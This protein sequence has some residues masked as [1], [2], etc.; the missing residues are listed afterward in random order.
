M[1]QAQIKT[2]SYRKDRNNGV[3]T[4]FAILYNLEL[5]EDVQEFGVVEDQETIDGVISEEEHYQT[6]AINQVSLNKY[7][8]V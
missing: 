2:F 3:I 5:N 4:I 7:E 8:I 6:E 1:I